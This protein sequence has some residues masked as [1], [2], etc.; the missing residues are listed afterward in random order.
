MKIL[1][2]LFLL[3]SSQVL[4]QSAPVITC[5]A[6]GS[7]VVNNVKFDCGTAPAPNPTPAPAPAPVPTACTAS[8]SS[9]LPV[10]LKRVCTASYVVGAGR[11]PHNNAPV[12]DLRAYVGSEITIGFG[13]TIP[14]TAY[15]ALSFVPVSGA[16]MYIGS[17]STLGQAPLW[18]VSTVP[19]DFSGALGRNCIKTSGGWLYFAAGATQSNVCSLTAGEAYYLNISAVYTN[20]M[21]ACAGGASSCAAVTIGEAI[22]Y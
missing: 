14:S 5:L 18:S 8:P 20:G 6:P 10:M 13:L 7:F 9:G 4:A 21:P 19:G 16:P 17:N 2:G 12:S 3:F 1:C 15:V 11:T 22:S